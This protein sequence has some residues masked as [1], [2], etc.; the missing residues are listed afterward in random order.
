MYKNNTTNVFWGERIRKEDSRLLRQG[1]E[2]SPASRVS[3]LTATEVAAGASASATPRKYNQNL[4]KPLPLTEHVLRDN[5]KPEISKTNSFT[6][7]NTRNN[8]KATTTFP[9]NTAVAVTKGKQQQQR[10]GT[11]SASVCSQSSAE[12]AINNDNEST[13]NNNDNNTS[14]LLQQRTSKV[15]NWIHSVPTELPPIPNKFSSFASASAAG[16][17]VSGR[18]V[19]QR[20]SKCESIFSAT[21][22]SHHAAS[23]AVVSG[24]TSINRRLE[25]IEERIAGEKELRNELRKALQEVRSIVEKQKLLDGNL[26]KSMSSASGGGS[27]VSGGSR[28]IYV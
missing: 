24:V 25:A 15:D 23:S 9:L 20:S 4:L 21:T 8:T 17:V 5:E 27:N 1:D 3:S 11:S 10:H 22:L 26:K 7:S 16:S 13:R 2:K 28:K 18:S 19:G 12:K 6:I 14:S